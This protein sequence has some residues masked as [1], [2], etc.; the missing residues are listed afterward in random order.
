MTLCTV[1]RWQLT[2]QGHVQGVGFR[3][4]VYRL[5]MELALAG[6]VKNTPQGV[7]IEIEGPEA[8]FWGEGQRQ[9]AREKD[10]IQE[11]I[12]TLHQG[13]ILAIKGLGGFQLLVDASNP[14]AVERWPST[15]RLLPPAVMSSGNRFVQTN[16]KQ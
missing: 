12:A 8:K 5:A 4:F 1:H 9:E 10:A 6:S 14:T 13:K 7:L 15:P 11:A 2:L 3:P 16:M